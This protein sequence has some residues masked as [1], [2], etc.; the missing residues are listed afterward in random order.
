MAEDE[1]DDAR[2][3]ARDD[4]APSVLASVRRLLD[5]DRIYDLAQIAEGAD[6]APETVE[7]LFNAAG[8]LRD[9]GKYAASDIA[10]AND[11]A[12]I[13]RRMPV[14]AVERSLRARI[15]SVSQIVVGELSIARLDRAVV[16]ALETGAPPERIGEALADVAAEIIPAM[17]RLLAADHRY[18][19]RELLDSQV[20]E[21]AA[22]QDLERQLDMAVAFVDLVG[23]TRLS[24]A[25]DPA[26]VGGV[27]NAFEDRVTEI[28]RDVGDILVAKTIGDAV[29]LLSGDPDL[30]TEALL[31]IVTEPDDELGDVGRRAGMAFGEVLVRDGDYIGAT[32]N[33]A[34]RLTD[35]ARPASLVVATDVVD[36]HVR[37]WQYSTLPP[38]RLKGIG[39]RRP[40]RVRPPNED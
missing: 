3:D 4:P 22:S 14:E 23:F 15:R 17:G 36:H 12:L 13:V 25:T 11:L 2:D 8:R 34:A 32:V 7:R 6:L 1:R 18:I 38:T 24:A 20:V 40:V 27:L 19:M 37:D 29:M 39:T 21:Q 33:L 28:V 5:E 9:D 31:R 26:G 35:L 16:D 30:L 10:Y